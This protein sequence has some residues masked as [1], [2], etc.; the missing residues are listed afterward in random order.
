MVWGHSLQD[1]LL[2]PPCFLVH[3]VSTVYLV[4]QDNKSALCPL[5]FISRTLS[6]SLWVYACLVS[7]FMI[8]V[9]CCSTDIRQKM[10]ERL[11][12]SESS[13]PSWQA[14]PWRSIYIKGFPD[15]CLF[16]KLI[17]CTRPSQVFCASP[18]QI[19][20]ATKAADVTGLQVL[21]FRRTWL[22]MCL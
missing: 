4:V 12:Y 11:W 10:Q 15:I 22:G 2:Q 7:K 19:Q 6:R 3:Q 13:S 1:L 17:R 18:S 5:C 21:W 8:R 14:L 9:Y 16:L 20:L